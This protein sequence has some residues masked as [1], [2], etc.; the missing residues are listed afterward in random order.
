MALPAL[1]HLLRE[2]DNRWRGITRYGPLLLIPILI[3]VILLW[4]FTA[5]ALVHSATHVQ[6]RCYGSE[7]RGTR[8]CYTFHGTGIEWKNTTSAIIHVFLRISILIFESVH[9]PLHLWF[10][11]H[12]RLHPAWAVSLAVI[13]M[14]AWW[15]CATWIFTYDLLYE[16]YEMG[17]YGG[18]LTAAWKGLA[19][20]RAVLGFGV[21][22]AYTVYMGFAAHAVKR[23]RRAKKGGRV[24]DR[25]EGWRSGMGRAS[26]E[27]EVNE[28]DRDDS[29]ELGKL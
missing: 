29:M 23:W 3:A 13:L 4:I 5:A 11:L 18:V 26:G 28:E 21:A 16:Y 15:C 14:G 7:S 8:R 1:Q 24:A 25:E 2:R 6:T 17:R 27:R 20:F 19:I 10:Y 9:V 12:S 22:L